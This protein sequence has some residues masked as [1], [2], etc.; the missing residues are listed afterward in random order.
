MTFAEAKR[1]LAEAG[2][3]DAEYSASE[4]FTELGG[5]PRLKLTLGCA[6]SDSPQVIDA[7][8]RRAE[9]EPLQY[10][11][12]YTYFYREKYRVTPA[13][14]IPRSDT[15]VLVDTAVRM[16]PKGADFLDLCTGSGCVG[17][18]TLK[19]TVGTAATLVDISADALE[20]ARL[21]AEENQV[22]DRATFLEMNVLEELPQGSFY[23]VLSNP[24]YVSIGAYGELPEELYREPSIAL[25]GG[26]DGGDFYRSLTPRILPIL[27][28]GGFIA[29]EIGYDQAQLLREIAEKHSL[30]CRIIKD[31]SGNDRVALLVK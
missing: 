8:R 29:Y 17:I 21:N 23:A 11:I 16:L 10:I 20:V 12:G 31:L 22:A 14:L 5:I 28:E 13:C 2:V 1:I 25:L 18:S 24:P 9:R 4:I 26:E 3:P 27:A 15:E 30:Q 19:N 6:E 7:V